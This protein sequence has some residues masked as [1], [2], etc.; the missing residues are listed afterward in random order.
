MSQPLFKA[1]HVAT[2]VQWMADLTATFLATWKQP[3]AERRA[4]DVDAT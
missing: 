1:E 4:R 2:Q 3:A